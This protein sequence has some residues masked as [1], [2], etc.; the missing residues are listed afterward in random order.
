MA[1]RLLVLLPLALLGTG[2][3]AWGVLAI[4]YSDI[5]SDGVRLALAV[6]FAVFGLV[7]VGAFLHPRTRWWAAASFV[8]GF[9]LVLAW[10]SGIPPSND[11]DWAPEYAVVPRA[12][13]DGDLVTLHDVRNFDYRTETDFTPRYEERRCDLRRLES[14]DLVASYWMG[15][16]I[17][18]VMLSF[19]FGGEDFVAV[20]VETRRERTEG[21]STI[22]GFFKRYELFYVV[23][24]ERDLIR[25]RT[26]YRENPPEDVYVYRTNAP[27]ERIRRVFLDYVREINSLAEEPRW[28]NTLTTNC[29]TAIVT[30][31]R[32]NP[33]AAP[34]SWKVLL[35]G[36][37]PR[38]AWERG[39]L[40]TRLSF[41]E[42]EKRSRVNEAARAADRAPDFSRRIRVG[43]PVPLPR[44]PAGGRFGPREG[45]AGR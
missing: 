42:L 39:A 18:H 19:G 24:D 23:A 13:V 5:E 2:A 16:A 27:P 25:L 33:G 6:A 8:V 43:L 29:T 44:H 21:Y 36:Y 4:R 31:L 38:Y 32:V 11:R 40:D 22:A 28:Y 17:A 35:S 20:S 9:G 26:N 12:T 15:E 3:T 41:E 34:M 7:A 30:H 1:F 10:W 45:V 14:L 37:A